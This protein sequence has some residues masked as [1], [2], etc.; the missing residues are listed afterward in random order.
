MNTEKVALVTGCSSGF[1]RVISE[2]LA[3]KNYHVFATMRA[4]QSRN[5]NA[6]R[7]LHEA[8]A[9]ESLPLHVLELDVTDDASVERAVDAVIKEAGRIDVL[10]NNAG[11][12]LHGLLEA[13]TIEQ[14]Q[15]IV[16]IN[17]FGVV[18]MNRAVLPHMRRQGSGLLLHISSMAG[19]IVV[20]GLGIYSASKF[21]LEAL[22]EAYHYELAS[23]GIDSVILEPG[24]YATAI[25]QNVQA[26][27]DQDRAAPYG[28]VSEISKKLFANIG[29]RRNPQEVADL[30]LHLIETPAGRR[31]LRVAVGVSD[32]GLRDLNRVSEQL[33]KGFLNRTGLAPLT[34]FQARA[35]STD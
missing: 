32:D 25:S 22:A 3:R 9:R 19:R 11:C 23:Q 18:R 30:V 12:S 29:P 28:P 14:V 27:A 21:A 6:A 8:A 35:A 33:Q 4:L 15:R 31:P 2:T 34:T 17:F 5:A 1:G 10:V 20:P 26:A 7:E 16:D 24:A 13:S